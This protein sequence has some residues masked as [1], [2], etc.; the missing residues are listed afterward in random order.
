MNN[1]GGPPGGDLI[2]AK[3]EE[4]RLSLE[5]HV[6]CNQ[7][8]A[9]AFVPSMKELGFGRIINIISTSVIQVIPGLGVSNTT[10]GAV[11]NWARTL[12][13][14]LGQ[15]GITVNNILPGYTDTGRLQSLAEAQAADQGISVNEIRAGWV[16]SVPLGRIGKPGEIASV[17]TFLASDT[18]GYINGVDIPVD[19]GRV[20]T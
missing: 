17:A 13:L 14:E 7:I 18:A 15:F 9:K 4:F 19:G 8:L 12:A 11:A 6:I 2:E 3:K 20:G 10:R 5:R 16:K 1:S